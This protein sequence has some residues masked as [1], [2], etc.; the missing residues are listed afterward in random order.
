MKADEDLNHRRIYRKKQFGSGISLGEKGSFNLETA[1]R[2]DAEAWQE[3][4][5]QP[6]PCSQGVLA[7]G[8]VCKP[9]AHECW[10][11]GQERWPTRS[12]IRTH[13]WPTHALVCKPEGYCS[14]AATPRGAIPSPWRCKEGACGADLKAMP[15][16]PRQHEKTST[17]GGTFP[18]MAR[19]GRWRTGATCARF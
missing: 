18:G 14:Q 15:W 2:G 6:L 17:F 7:H 4:I 16:R 5:F 9:F 12:R 3:L 10:L 11:I 13:R 1:Y 8:R 19:A